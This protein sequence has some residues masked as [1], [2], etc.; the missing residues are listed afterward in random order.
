MLKFINKR[1]ECI[2]FTNRH[3]TLISDSRKR[4]LITTGKFTG[5]SY[6]NFVTNFYVRVCN[7]F[8]N[9]FVNLK[10]LN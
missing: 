9:L 3:D 8:T 2:I 4:K 7:M 10:N 5:E 6:R 1:F